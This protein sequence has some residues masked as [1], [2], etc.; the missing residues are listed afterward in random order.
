MTITGK[1]R[2][3]LR[4]RHSHLTVTRLSADNHLISIAHI[5][6]ACTRNENSWKNM[7]WENSP[8][9][10]KTSTYSCTNFRK[11]IG[12]GKLQLVSFSPKIRKRLF[13][14][15]QE[16]PQRWGVQFSSL[17]LPLKPPKLGHADLHNFELVNLHRRSCQGFQSTSRKGPDNQRGV[18]TR[19]V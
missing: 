11:Y 2:S 19:V 8:R 16:L 4:S 1:E 3:R 17:C 15:A 14:I 6:T 7:A 5:G 9:G 13:Y 18:S 10:F 12:R